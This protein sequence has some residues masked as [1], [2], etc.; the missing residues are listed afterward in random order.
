[1]RIL[2]PK[3]EPDLKS[4]TDITIPRIS[5]WS[6]DSWLTCFAALAGILGLMTI[7]YW[8]SSIGYWR[9]DSVPYIG[10]KL[11]A[12]KQHQEGRWI[13]F[14]L[15]DSVKNFSPYISFVIN[16]FI[17]FVSIFL[18]SNRL[19]G[20]LFSKTVVSATCVL[21]PGFYAQNMWPIYTNVGLFLLLF[22]IILMIRFGYKCI[23]F[24]AI[25]LF[26][27]IPYFY[28]ILPL[29]FLPLDRCNG[30]KDTKRFITPG[31]VWGSGLIVAYGFAATLNVL[32]VGD[33]GIDLAEWRNPRPVSNFATLWI[34]LTQ[35]LSAFGTHVQR[36]LPTPSLW[37][38]GLSTIILST[39]SIIR[40]NDKIT[41][42]LRF[43]YVT[44]V[45]SAPYITTLFVGIYIQYRSLLPMAIGIIFLPFV[46]TDRKYHKLLSIICVVFIAIPS[47]ID[48]KSGV[49]WFSKTTQVTMANIE[50]TLPRGGSSYKQVIIDTRDASA[51]FDGVRKQMRD[52]PKRPYFME[53]L[54]SPMRLVPAFLEKG[55]RKVTLCSD[56]GVETASVE[57]KEVLSN[58]DWMGSCQNSLTQIC[59]IG[60]R[61]DSFLIRLMP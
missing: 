15:F 3:S 17:L 22:S 24:V 61:N 49:E 38:L 14:L 20:D 13:Q 35:N 11:L 31:I 47:F 10:E 7:A 39:L 23:I 8:A 58:L 37:A 16:I 29:V 5:H 27:S 41:A 6:Y 53:T 21:F 28:Y 56:E 40:N 52:L 57:C 1:M 45:L 55:F 18:I 44:V 54:Y 4:T 33:F 2:M 30:L 36:W 48:S 46:I 34:N 59:V 42:L 9:H 50:K 51:Y 26:A 43:T 60:V 25:I 12:I 19:L 32:L